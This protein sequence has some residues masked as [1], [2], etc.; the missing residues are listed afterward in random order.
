MVSNKPPS[1]RRKWK[2]HKVKG[3]AFVLLNKPS[4]IKLGKPARIELGLIIDISLGGLAAQYV[5]S[6]KQPSEFKHLAISTS[7]GGIQIDEI[8]FETISDTEVAKL[9]DSRIIRNCCLSFG[10]LMHDQRFKLESFIKDY[11]LEIMEDRRAV[12]DRRIS[13]DPKFDD[14]EYADLYEKR[15]GTD[16]RLLLSQRNRSRS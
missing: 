10:N 6:K 1:K 15:T 13:H 7:S 4:L 3:G 5:E 16:R 12:P 9:P 8:P 11:S 14:K 2:R